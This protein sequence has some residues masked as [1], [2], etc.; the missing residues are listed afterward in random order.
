VDPDVERL[1]IARERY[2][3]Q[4]LYT[5]LDEMLEKSFTKRA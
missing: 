2:G 3:P 1:E 5:D 4:E